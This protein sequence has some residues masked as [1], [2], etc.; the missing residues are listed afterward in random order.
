MPAKRENLWTRCIVLWTVREKDYTKIPF[1]EELQCEGL[2]IQVHKTGNGLP[3]LDMDKALSSIVG[4][5]GQSSW[6]Y[7]SG[8]G[9]FISSAERACDRVEGMSWFA[10]RWD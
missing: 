3:R 8:P 9:G 10:A 6:C 5:D 2:E 1:L 7:I 4:Q